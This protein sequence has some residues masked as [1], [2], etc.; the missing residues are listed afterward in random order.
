MVGALVLEHCSEAVL[1]VKRADRTILTANERLADIT[2]RPLPDLVGLQL[3]E[4]IAEDGE[5]AAEI[6]GRPGLHEEVAIRRLDGYPLFA[7]MTVAHLDDPHIGSIAALIARDT[8]E[9][10]LL[11]R[12]LIAKHTALY[13]AHA[14]LESAHASL[15]E[16]NRELEARTRELALMSS[17][18]SVS[19]RRALIGELSAG[20]AHGLNNP[21]AALASTQTQLE[22]HIVRL[23]TPELCAAADKYLRRS[24][25]AIGRMEQLV[26]AVREAF[27]SGK[28]SQGPRDIAVVDEVESALVLFESRLQAIRVVRAF[29]GAP[30][31]FAPPGDVQNI[32]WNLLDNAVLA[33]PDGGELTIAVSAGG[34]VVHLSVTDDGAG[35]PEARRATLFEPFL[36]ERPTGTGLGLVTSRRLARAW[37]GDVALGSSPRGA[38]FEVTLPARS[39]PC[40][41]SAS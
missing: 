19:M 40:S 10:R 15:T 35:V 29:A 32:L 37:G 5:P 38:C 7:S 36:S 20:V 22:S 1:T 4:L 26:G 33:M 25:Q 28:P 18:L 13:A 12:E 6:V 11:E 30:H 27:R 21:L 16:R 9:R 24:R 17:E 23:G 3:D 34:G 41:D 2:G 39:Q 31:A 14:D 8:T